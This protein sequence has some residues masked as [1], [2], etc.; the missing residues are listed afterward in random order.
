MQDGKKGKK[1]ANHQELTK[2]Y[3]STPAPPLLIPMF[4]D[5]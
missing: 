4:K 3:P 1:K 2:N 5:H